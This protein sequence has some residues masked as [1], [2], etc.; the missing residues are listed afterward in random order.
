MDIQVNILPDMLNFGLQLA[1]TLVL[2]LVL[3]HFLFDP[4][5]KHLEA[6]GENIQKDLDEAKAEREQAISLK[7]EY[8]LNIENAKSEGRDIVEAAKKRGDQ[9]RDEIILEARKEAENM[10][11]KAKNDIQREKEKALDDL[12][13]EVATIAMLAASKVVEK[14]L[15]NN[16]HKDMIN[17]FIDEVGEV[18]WQN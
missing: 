11:A 13:S 8:E 12:K 3:R 1:A 6:R 9:L 14:N 2:F 15:D 4:V 18:K 10:A 17:K 16:A 7:K 5:K